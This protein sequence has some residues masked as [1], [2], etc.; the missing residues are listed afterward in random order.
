MNF[1]QCAPG[2]LYGGI[3]IRVQ[4]ESIVDGIAFLHGFQG[5][6]A[7]ERRGGGGHSV[8]VGRGRGPAVCPRRIAGG[9][10]IVFPAV[11]VPVHVPAVG[12]KV[13]KE[14]RGSVNEGQAFQGEAAAVIPQGMVDMADGNLHQAALDRY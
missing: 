2:I 7:H 13:W 4:D 14:A 12:E 11:R 6:Q 10:M 9:W 8:P 1:C 3:G 5:G